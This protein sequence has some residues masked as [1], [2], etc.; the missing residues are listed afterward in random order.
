M[1]NGNLCLKHE[2][3]C[4]EFAHLLEFKGTIFPATPQKEGAL[5]RDNDGLHNTLTRPYFPN[6]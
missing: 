4:W 1:F 6:F 2:I 5:L 3:V